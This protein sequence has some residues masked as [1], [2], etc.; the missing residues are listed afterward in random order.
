MWAVEHYEGVEPDLVV[1]GKSLGGGLPLA[2]VTGRAEIMDAP[3][4]GGLGGTFGG[5]PVACAAAA[6]VLDTVAEPAFRARADEL[7][8]KLRG[9]LD[10]LASRHEQI[11]EVRGLG[12]MLALE[13]REQSPDLA[14]KVTAAAFERG[15]LLLSCGLYGNVI[16]LLPPLTVTDDELD[17]GLGLLEES[18][19]PPQAEIDVRVAGLRK[20]YGEVTAVDGVDLEIGRGEFFTLLGPS[21]SGKT[22]TLRV[23]AGFELPDEGSVELGGKDVSRLPPYAR[24]VNTVFQ[25][26]ALFPHMTVQENIEYGL[27]VKKVP[28]AERRQR[29]GEALAARAARGATAPASRRSSPAASGSVSRSPARSSTGRRRSSSTSRS[30][31][32][33]SSCARSCRSS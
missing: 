26:Y 32:S 24:D 7:G 31:R 10:E 33:T 21:G 30:A 13:L 27:R 16:R 20:S 22:T 19:V 29:A 8:E 2:A 17:R 23:I 12:P 11:G 3:G 18:F 9:R 4:P 28:R 25:D 1:S 5:N 14:G 15:L 6:V